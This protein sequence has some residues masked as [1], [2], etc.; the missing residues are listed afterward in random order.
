MVKKHKIPWKGI[1]WG[2]LATFFCEETCAYIPYSAHTISSNAASARKDGW[3]DVDIADARD[4]EEV[5]RRAELYLDDSVDA[6]TAVYLRDVKRFLHGNG[7]EISSLV[8]RGKK[9]AYIHARDGERIIAREL[10]DLYTVVA[11]GEGAPL[12]CWDSVDTL[13]GLPH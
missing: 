7:G 1:F 13:M 2:A 4:P 12:T 3:E 5:A 6:Q 10:R 8:K 11:L 9:L